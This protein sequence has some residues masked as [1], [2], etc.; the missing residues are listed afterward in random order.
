VLITHLS[1]RNIRSFNDGT[2]VNIDLPEGTVLFEGDVGSGKSTILYAVEFALFGLGD[3]DGSYLL[4]E[5]ANSG[6][7]KV[8]ILQGHKTLEVHRGL[9]RTGGNVLQE[10]CY[11]SEDGTVSELSPGDLKQRVIG[12]LGF[13]EPSH[14]RAESLVFRYAVFTPQEQMKE[15]IQRNPDERL[16]VIRRV[17]GIQ[18]YQVAAENSDLIVKRL[19]NDV[20]NAEAATEDLEEM[21]E[22]AELERF[23]IKELDLRIPRLQMEE[24]QAE[25]QTESLS[26]KLEEAKGERERIGAIAERIPEIRR[27]MTR[28]QSDINEDEGRISDLERRIEQEYI[29]SMNAFIEKPPPT[30][31]RAEELER[32]LGSKK[33]SLEKRRATSLLLAGRLSE[34]KE[35]VKN[36][37]C[38]RCGQRISR[39]FKD[40]SAH[41]EEELQ[42][43]QIEVAALDEEVSRLDSLLERARRYLEEERK[44]IHESKQKAEMEIE[45]GARRRHAT[46]S[47]CEAQRL[48]EDLSKTE[49]EEARLAELK[50]KIDAITRDLRK[51]QEW[52]EKL[53]RTLTEST[54]AK[55]YAEGSL[56]KLVSQIEA[57][58]KKREQVKRLR[59]HSS[60]LADFFKPTV[61]LI[62]RQTMIQTNLRFSQHFQRFFS[63]LVDDP[64][65][66]V[67][68]TDDFSP[69]FER[70]GYVQEF[71]TLSGG[72]RTSIALA[73]R[74]ALNTIVQEDIGTGTGDLV[75]LDEPTDGFSKEQIQKMRE[76][77]GALHSRQVILV[78]HEKELES[79]A[80]RM[81][82]VEKV[83]GTSKV[84]PV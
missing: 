43:V 58:R 1:L 29:P 23:R 15:I 68:V 50:S 9:K 16:H 73:Y 35:L 22:E 18:S 7:A 62:E 33:M 39:D 13:N 79:M 31:L 70:Q 8:R 75:I 21:E 28:L 20:R 61:E 10:S 78:S 84:S 55:G 54:T 42:S 26:A 19:R 47:R 14:P 34:T 6:Y 46:D 60:W 36:G 72:E 76:I 38:P 12:E 51:S 81:M 66:S 27:S 2:D 52:K 65:L 17:L 41:L 44:Y 30:E 80:D 11:I 24:T 49:A 83:N 53:A 37:V 64:D 48:G 57:K 5:G 40:Q 3:M 4:S 32:D 56:V 59:I 82:L 69:V 63:Y 71:D 74:L 45:I 67:R 77:L 25:Y